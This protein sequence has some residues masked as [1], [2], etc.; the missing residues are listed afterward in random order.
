MI[1]WDS[2]KNKAIDIGEWSICGGVWDSNNAIDIGRWSI[3]GG[4]RLERFYCIYNMRAIALCVYR[5]E[6]KRKGEK[7]KEVEKVKESAKE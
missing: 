4:G 5:R 1:V 2:N 7:H 3:C 6:R